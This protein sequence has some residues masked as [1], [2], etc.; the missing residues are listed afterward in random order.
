M[1]Q[2]EVAE[3]R[4]R[5]VAAAIDFVPPFLLFLFFV[6]VGFTNLATLTALFGSI[7]LVFRDLIAASV[8]EAE[9]SVQKIIDY[10]DRA[11]G[12]GFETR[13]V[14]VTDNAVED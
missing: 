7:Y 9:L 10:E 8:R 6:G 11:F 3:P 1:V 2:I 14:F 12:V 13:A 4:E 5:F